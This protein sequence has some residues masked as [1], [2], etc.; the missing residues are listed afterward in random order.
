MKWQ[1]PLL[2]LWLRPQTVFFSGQDV[3]LGVD[4]LGWVYGADPRICSG[5]KEKTSDC[6]QAQVHN[7]DLNLFMA[8]G[9]LD[10]FIDPF[11][12]YSAVNEPFCCHE[13]VKSFHSLAQDSN[14]DLFI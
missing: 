13:L 10:V 2:G 8:I 12:V 9:W 5:V 6:V 3:I 11:R 4:G 1:W 7:S 14:A